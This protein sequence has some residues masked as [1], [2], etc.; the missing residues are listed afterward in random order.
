MPVRKFL[1]GAG[2]AHR[3]WHV[4]FKMDWR[5]RLVRLDR[6]GGPDGDR[7]VHADQQLREG[8]RDRSANIGS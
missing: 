5:G 4:G 8:S 1:G 3:T 2:K 7:G 6:S